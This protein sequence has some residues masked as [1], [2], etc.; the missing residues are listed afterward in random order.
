MKPLEGISSNFKDPCSRVL[1]HS[2]YMLQGHDVVAIACAERHVVGIDISDNAIKKAAEI[3]DHEG[4]PPYSVSV[5]D[6]EEALHP[7][8]FNATYIAENELAIAPRLGREKLGRWKR[9]GR[10]SSL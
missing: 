8:G 10:Q 7:V 1:V 5:A 6:Y 3:D 2:C 9:I 4:G